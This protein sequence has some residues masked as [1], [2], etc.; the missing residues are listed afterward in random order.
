M[1]TVTE[2]AAQLETTPESI[3]AAFA[4]IDQAPLIAVAESRFVGF[5]WDRTSPLLD[6]PAEHWLARADI[7]PDGAIYVFQDTEA[8]GQVFQP[9]DPEMPGLVAMDDT[10]ALALVEA[11]RQ[12]MIRHTVLMAVSG[13]IRPSLE[14]QGA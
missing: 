4:A 14:G 10:R 12:N 9:H 5:L 2:V 7:L 6:Q 8:S 11:L 3:E 1:V 13:M